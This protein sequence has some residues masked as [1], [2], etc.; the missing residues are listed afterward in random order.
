[1]RDLLKEHSAY[2]GPI[3]RTLR[4][5]KPHVRIRCPKCWQ[6]DGD[7]GDWDDGNGGGGSGHVCSHCGGDSSR[8]LDLI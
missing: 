3:E 6:L 2:A 1:M 8:D 5:K 7:M 4:L